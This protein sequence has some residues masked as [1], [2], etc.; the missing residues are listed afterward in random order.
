MAEEGGGGGG[1]GAWACKVLIFTVNG[2]SAVRRVWREVARSTALSAEYTRLKYLQ[3]H[4]LKVLPPP[5]GC[6]KTSAW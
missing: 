1:G 6:Q 5:S 4:Q 3:H 2:V